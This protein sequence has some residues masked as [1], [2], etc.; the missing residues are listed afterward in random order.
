MDIKKIFITVCLLMTAGFLFAADISFVVY[1]AKGKVTK[2]GSKTLLKKGDPLLAT[3]VLSIGD[4]SS[5]VLVCSNYK[6]VQFNKKGNYP[7]RTLLLQCN[8][9]AA[10]YTGN[11]FKYVWNEFTHKHGKPEANPEEYMNNVGAVSR[12]CNTVQLGIAA[13]SIHYFTGN[14]SIYWSSVWDTTIAAIYD[15]PLDG[16]PLQTTVLEKGQPLQMQ[17]LV[18]GLQPGIYYWQMMDK[19]GNACERTYLKL[20]EEGSYKEEVKRLTGL[21]IVSTPAETAFAT[22]FILQENHFVAEALSYYQLAA[23]LDHSNIIYKKAVEKFYETD[24]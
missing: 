12:G 4:Q 8:N 5:V 23:K 11:Y 10:S 17:Q 22:A 16:A 24:F 7:A 14:L 13:D 15:M 3:D 21:A 6:A 20:W 19:Q 1:Y 2:A 9:T 18:K